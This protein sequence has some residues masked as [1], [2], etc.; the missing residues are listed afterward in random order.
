MHLSTN[1]IMHA[2]YIVYPAMFTQLLV[3]YPVSTI[4]IEYYIWK[5][6]GKTFRPHNINI[7]YAPH[8]HTCIY[9]NC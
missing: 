2:F 7:K 8:T 3:N 6:L 1:K 5:L 9:G 4:Y